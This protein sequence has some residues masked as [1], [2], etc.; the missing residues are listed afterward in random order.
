MVLLKLIR[1]ILQLLLTRLF[2]QIV[3]SLDAIDASRWVTRRLLVLWFRLITTVWDAWSVATG[4]LDNWILGGLFIWFLSFSEIDTWILVWSTD[5][6]RPILATGA[7]FVQVDGSIDSRVLRSSLDCLDTG[8]T[9]ALWPHTS[10]LPF[11]IIPTTLA[12]IISIYVRTWPLL[13]II[14]R[15][16][17]HKLFLVF[18]CFSTL[19]LGRIWANF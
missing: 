9:I 13:S 6:A 12:K 2:F 14:S 16:I 3:G 1:L 8:F 5:G 11:S 4:H 15:I 18:L 7:I 17:L 10:S 19:F